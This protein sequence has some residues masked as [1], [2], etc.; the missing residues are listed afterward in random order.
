MSLVI[1]IKDQ[2]GS[3]FVN[4]RKMNSG[5]QMFCCQDQKR[6]LSNSQMIRMKH[7]MH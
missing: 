4:L 6:M 5:Y 7:V 1:R 2:F 3:F